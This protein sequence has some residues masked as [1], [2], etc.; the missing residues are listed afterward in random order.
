[1]IRD[2]EERRVW[3]SLEAMVGEAATELDALDD[4]EP[5][6][7]PH[8]PSDDE[9][10]ALGATIDPVK[11]DAL[12]AQVQALIAAEWQRRLSAATTRRPTQRAPLSRSL[13]VA[14]L[15]ARRSAL[16][17]E[18]PGLAQY[19]R[20]LDDHLAPDVLRAQVEDM[21]ALVAAMADPLDLD[22][23]DE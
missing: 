10:R 1:M 18:H 22:D 9:L 3:L 17:A 12:D 8:E 7:A 16:M 13:S 4:G 21:E 2:E 6:L 14:E 19:H 11:V 15:L 20:E 23:T 5:E